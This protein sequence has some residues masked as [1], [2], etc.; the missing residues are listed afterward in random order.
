MPDAK[1]TLVTL[2]L[3]A[4]SL[5]A[6]APADTAPPHPIPPVPRTPPGRPLHNVRAAWVD[7]LKEPESVLYDA[8][9]D[10]YYVSNIDGQSLAKDGRGFISRLEGDGTRDALRWIDSGRNGVT[11]HAPKGMALVGDTLWV[12]DVDAVRGFLVGT[13]APVAT[14]DLSSLGPAF[15]NDLAAGPDGALYATDTRMKA[16]A[17]GNMVKAGTDRVYRIANRRAT[18][19]LES[20]RLGR[21]NG[22]AWDGTNGR[23]VIVPFGGDT[24]TTWR[25]G[26]AEPAP[27]ATGPGQFDGVVV[28]ASGR[29]IVSSKATGG[30][31]ELKGDRLVTLA[32]HL[33]DVAD[34]WWDA[35]HSRIAV[36]L[37][38]EDRVEFYEV[39]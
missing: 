14:V 26:D 38:G 8:A 39:R 17:R 32:E 2:A 13:G 34:I 9:R 24:I 21:P 30:L 10:V 31:H 35:R 23:F 5:G 1:A 36:P 11:L 27:L 16:D 15:L 29:I 6:Q 4:A 12:N 37:T 7:G 28:S 33:G 20:D 22:I 18:V 25:P 3:A 19:A